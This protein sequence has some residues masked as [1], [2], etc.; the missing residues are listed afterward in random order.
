[1]PESHSTLSLVCLHYS[2]LPGIDK[3]QRSFL[4]YADVHWPSHYISQ[5]ATVANQFRKDACALC[6]VDG[7]HAKIWAPTYLEQRHLWVEKWTDLAWASYL[8]LMQVVE[9][10]FLEANIDVN[11][12]GGIYE[13][14]LLAASAEGHEGVALLLIE[15]GADVNA[16]DGYPGTALQVASAEDYESI[17]LLLLEKDADVNATSDGHF[18]TALQAAEAGGYK[19]IVLLLFEKGVD[20]ATRSV[21]PLSARDH[22]AGKPL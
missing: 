7:N 19:S 14:A 2:I 3:G 16:S 10:I 5:Q 6:H 1:M 13:T 20:V 21:G 15:K 18:G 12:E 9:D 8:G 22:E 4:P 17:V 11:A